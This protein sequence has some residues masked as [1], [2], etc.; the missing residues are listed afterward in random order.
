VGDDGIMAN[1]AQYIPSG[2]YPCKFVP[3]GIQGS[4]DTLWLRIS[5][6]KFSPNLISRGGVNTGQVDPSKIFEF[7]MPQSFG[8]GYNHTW[9][10]FNTI[11]GAVREI[12]S[13]ISKQSAALQQTTKNVTG[14]ALIGEGISLGQKNDNM[15]IYENTERFTV[16]IELSFAI[17]DDAKRDVFDPIKTL[18]EL[19]SPKVS[20]LDAMGT[21]IEF[22]YVF[23]VGV[24]TGKGKPSELLQLKDAAMNSIL[25]TWNG[26]YVRG[27]PSSA[28]VQI[29]FTDIYPVYRN[30]SALNDLRK[31]FKVGEK[32]GAP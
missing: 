25:P 19:S 2:R 9:N 22:P 18:M 32:T 13:E 16:Q 30:S 4:D 10:D 1:D 23:D 29:T 11:A 14:N 6:S 17:Y 27:Y 12:K 3:S 7:L 24:Y 15:Y 20:S 5:A 8:Y 28:T 26:P 31:G 21:S